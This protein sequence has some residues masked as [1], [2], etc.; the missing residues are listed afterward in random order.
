M[1]THFQDTPTIYEQTPHISRLFLP[2]FARLEQ[3]QYQ[4]SA[5]TFD[6]AAMRRQ[7]NGK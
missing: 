5:Y 4:A 6:K 2:H 7:A 3:P 1:Q